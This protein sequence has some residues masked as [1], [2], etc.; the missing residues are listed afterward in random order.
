MPSN[1]SPSLVSLADARSII[2]GAPSRSTLFNWLR[3]GILRGKRV[4]GRRFIFASSIDKL[5]SDDADERRE[6]V[7]DVL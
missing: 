3:R 2:P 6:E 1:G 7:G 5:V 4:G